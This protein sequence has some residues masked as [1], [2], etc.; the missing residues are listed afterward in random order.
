MV[1]SIDANK[2]EKKETRTLGVRVG[3]KS[4]LT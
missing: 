3:Q 4:L 1:R 2:L